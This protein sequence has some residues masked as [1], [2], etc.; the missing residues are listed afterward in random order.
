MNEMIA[1]Q[2]K[3]VETDHFYTTK[4]TTALKQAVREKEMKVLG[5]NNF[6]YNIRTANFIISKNNTK[7]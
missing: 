2:C 6:T 7:N 1:K 5:Q 4:L 3:T